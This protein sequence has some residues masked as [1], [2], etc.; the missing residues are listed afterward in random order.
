MNL[1]DLAK[2]KLTL[3][4][5]HIN[6]E[7]MTKLETADLE[8]KVLTINDFDFTTDKESGDAFAVVTFKEVPNAFYFGG[9]VLTDLMGSIA[10]DSEA[11]A[12]FEKTGLA[13]TFRMEKCKKGNKSYVKVEIV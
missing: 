2:S 13:V 7:G 8:N 9:M 3:T 5:G 11:M 10:Q 4:F 12:E 1:K 6:P